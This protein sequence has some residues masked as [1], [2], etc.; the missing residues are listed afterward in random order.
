MV[1]SCGWYCLRVPH[2]CLI[3]KMTLSYELWKLKTTF[4]D[5]CN[6]YAISH[7]HDCHS[8]RGPFDGYPSDAASIDQWINTNKDWFSRHP[9]FGGIFV[10][11]ALQSKVPMSAT[12][13][14]LLQYSECNPTLMSKILLLTKDILESFQKERGRFFMLHFCHIFYALVMI[15]YTLP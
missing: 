6:K 10:R 11:N 2:V 13:S 1:K 9:E 3:T 8:P 4:D 7:D 5:H 12:T 14:R 15:L